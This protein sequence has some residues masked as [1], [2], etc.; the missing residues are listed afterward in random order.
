MES[1]KSE[2]VIS[3]NRG[4]I[5][6]ESENT[7]KTAE[8]RRRSTRDYTDRT[9]R[10]SFYRKIESACGFKFEDLSSFENFVRLLYRPTDP[11]SLGIT[12][13]LFGICMVVDVVEERG[14]ADI[15]IKWGDP[16]DCH[17]PLIHGMTPPSLSWMIVLYGAMWLGAFGL[18]LGFRFKVACALFVLPYWYLFLLDK[19]YWNNHTYLYGIVATLLWCTDANKY[20][21]FDAKYVKRENDTV[22]LW[23][24]FILKFQFFALYFLAGLK[25]SGKEWLEGYSMTNLSRHWVFDPFKI[26]LTTEETDFFIV[27]WFGF[28]FDLTV[29]F[30]MLFDKTRL[31]AMIFCTAFHLM[32][33]R[34][35]SIGM[36][37]YV[38]LATMP[39]FCN[40]DW[41]R[42]LCTSIK[43]QRDLLLSKCVQTIKN[44]LR[45]PV[46]NQENEDEYDDSSSNAKSVDDPKLKDIKPQKVTKKQKFVVS[47]LL[48]HI[49]LQ[50][51]LPY[52]HFITKGYNNWVPGLYGYS[53]DMMVHTWDTILVVIR[54]HDNENNE[55][56]YLDPDTWVQGDRWVKHG[57][58]ARQYAFCLKDNILRQKGETLNKNLRREEREK[59][60]KLSSNLSIYI[61][62]WCSLNGRFQQRIFDPNVDMLTVDWHPFKSVSF[63]MPLLTQY[64]SYRYKLDEIQRDVYSWSNYTDVLFVADFPNMSLENYIGDDF[65]NVSLTVLEGEVVYNEE[66]QGESFV[67]P[68]GS[69]I[70]VRTDKFH[71]IKTTSPYPACYMYTYTN[72]TKQKLDIDR[73]TEDNRIKE[74]FSLTQELNYKIDSWARALSHLA[75]AFFNL[76]YDVPM[77]R[78]VREK[79]SAITQIDLFLTNDEKTASCLSSLSRP[80]RKRSLADWQTVVTTRPRGPPPPPPPRSW[81]GQVFSKQQIRKERKRKRNKERNMTKLNSY[82]VD[83]GEPLL[84][85]LDKLG[86]GSTFLWIIFIL[87]TIPTL[88][89]GMHSMAYIFIAEVPNHWCSIPILTSA[90]WTDEQ[91]RNISS[92]SPCTKYDYNYESFAEIGFEEA[93]KYKHDNPLPG[94]T[95]CSV[96]SFARDKQGTSFVEDWDL[97]CDRMADRTNTQMMFSLGKL[98]GAASFGIVSDK[99]GRKFAYAIGIVMLILSSPTSA[100]VP[101]FWGF[102]V[103]RLI[104]GISHAAILYPSFTLLTEVAS[105]KHRQWMG[106]AYNA[107]YPVG[108]AI[109]AGIAYGLDDWRHIQLAS[110][111]P[112]LILLLFMWLMPESPRWYLSQNRPKDAQKV[113]EKYYG[114]IYETTSTYSVSVVRKPM[115]EARSEETE[116]RASN[117]STEEHRIKAN[118]K[119]LLTLLLNGELCKRV[120]ITN[121]AWLTASLTYYALALNV[122]NFSADRYVYIFVMGITE[123]PAYLIPTPILMVFGRRQACALIYSLTAL[124]LL[125]ILLIPA[126]KTLTIVIVALTGRFALSTVYSIVILYTSEL[127]PTTTRNSAVGSSSAMSHVGSVASPYVADLLGAITWWAPSTL[128]GLCALLSGLLCMM[129][130]ETRGRSLA[131]T[132]DEEITKERGLV[133]FR[134]CFVCKR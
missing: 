93:V 5:I 74:P 73:Q 114:P 32:N 86:E 120:M 105:E 104:N 91:I 61:D 45:N 17:F 122:D 43:R 131:D 10:S 102:M 58:M 101:W 31:P 11:A 84:T 66:N 132:V 125:S 9:S 80:S 117:P 133:A 47:M 88:F 26:F 36:F 30:W 28:I 49:A 14:L 83:R 44:Y 67:L 134:N 4:T 35:F 103:L 119:G 39:L 118:I 20:F 129:L 96:R 94:A 72:E 57:D 7:W 37:P 16:W 60:R 22:P 95:E 85:A 126:T 33:S 70:G 99:C 34:L 1:T 127:F 15:D 42:A 27:H 123:I 98:L 46:D 97:V 29:G 25:K 63:V 76:V 54:V 90:N 55:D 116:D 64:N 124:C 81:Q 107:G 71:R 18:M 87:T 62:A 128:C 51:F 38:C 110:T 65:T 59:W 24:Y 48:I 77:I 69:S 21:A 109:M 92:A 19:S 78:R 23:N 121:F 100:I 130:P 6:E 112:T 106:V 82:Q 115:L 113:I 50:F 3:D 2:S 79:L 68:K 8:D 53:W 111:L 40:A 89:N 56:R 41:P 52:S 12:R 13:A 75:N 108:T